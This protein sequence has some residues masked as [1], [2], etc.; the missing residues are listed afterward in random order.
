MKKLLLIPLLFLPALI[1]S[2]GMAIAPGTAAHTHTDANSGGGTL[3]VSGT[4]SST[5]ACATG[6]TRKGPNYCARNNA[7]GIG[8]AWAD[9]VA[10]TARTS[11]PALPAD[12]KL[13]MISLHWRGLSNNAVGFRTNILNFWT[14]AACTASTAQVSSEASFREEVA[15][16]AGNSLG[17]VV[18]HLLVPLVTTNTFYTT[19]T[20]AGGN[21]SVDV[22]NWDVEGYTD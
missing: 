16:A 3:T 18:E 17:D 22:F 2:A 15:V 19:Q 11:T 8:Q 1:A 14:T 6:F 4:L 9:A 5:K 13:A 20:T 10:C 12:A 21:G 7:N